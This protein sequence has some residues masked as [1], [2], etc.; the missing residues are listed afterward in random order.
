MPKRKRLFIC[1]LI[2]RREIGSL[3]RD[4]T[5]KFIEA[6]TGIAD[7]LLVHDNVI[8]TIPCID[9]R[10]RSSYMAVT[11][12]KGIAAMTHS[13]RCISLINTGTMKRIAEIDGLTRTV[14]TLCFH[15]H[16]S[17][18]LATGDLGGT[19][20][21]FYGTT[22][23]RSRLNDSYPITS[24]SFHAREPLIFYSIDNR[25]VIW[26][27]ES[28]V[29]ITDLFAMEESR[30]KYVKY[31]PTNDMLITG[32]RRENQ[33]SS[34]GINDEPDENH[35]TRLISCSS[36]FDHLLRSLSSI[37]DNIDPNSFVNLSHYWSHIQIHTNT[38]YN[39][40]RSSYKVQLQPVKFIG[41]FNISLSLM[42]VRVHQIARMVFRCDN[43][44]NDEILDENSNLVDKPN[45]FTIRNTLEAIKYIL[46]MYKNEV[47]NFKCV[48]HFEFSTLAD[49]IVTI[50][51]ILNLN[52]LSNLIR[53]NIQ[54][55]DMYQY[56]LQAWNMENMD[57][58][59]LPDFSQNWRNL[60]TY[61]YIHNDST[62]ELSKCG[63]MIA[64][65]EVA[66][67]RKIIT[68]HSLEKSTLGQ[69]I[70]SYILDSDEILMSL[71]FSPSSEYLL[72]GVRSSEIFGCFLKII[73]NRTQNRFSP[74]VCIKSVDQEV[75][76]ELF[77][78]GDAIVML[79]RSL[80]NPDVIS[81][82]KWSARSGDGVI[83]GYKT[84]QLRCLVRR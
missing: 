14:W 74:P 44:S 66:S 37:I 27:Y 81:Y 38:Y 26:N 72:V 20:C 80:S 32:I 11:N 12:S 57:E 3:G 10:S 30:I 84:Y 28:D 4:E 42:Q 77:S 47:K 54:R 34:F 18:L 83:I 33:I 19:V 5:K 16:D 73:K 35:E 31:N 9:D 52:D 82:L 6:S 36:F 43:F 68:V 7:K 50:H 2:Q 78:G 39:A 55:S 69:Y 8:K 23:M 75:K 1:D 22:K 76:R 67:S 56:R 25:I 24:I 61:C 48:D 46:Q 21:V 70:C 58:T 49:I 15:P 65:F 53:Q 41:D 45:Y 64:S 13:N 40:L 62:V 17:N 51:R 79:K 60:I 71:S 59:Y 63:T 29:K